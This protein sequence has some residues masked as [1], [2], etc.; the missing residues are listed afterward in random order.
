MPL[1]LSF[2]SSFVLAYYFPPTIRNI[3]AVSIYYISH[4][5]LKFAAIPDP[6]R[7][8]PVLFFLLWS[9]TNGFV[10]GPNGFGWKQVWLGRTTSYFHRARRR[11]CQK[12]RRLCV[13]GS[14]CQEQDQCGTNFLWSHPTNQP[15]EPPDRQTQRQ[16]GWL[17]LVVNFTRP[18]RPKHRNDNW[19]EDGNC[20][21]RL[22]PGLLPSIQ[23]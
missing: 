16:E 1:S 12:I 7:V 3:L 9:S 13:F 18:R 17:H 22:C 5:I 2:A 20:I 8:L 6:L 23:P 4:N 10:I 14:L 11:A 21:D 15:Q 19:W